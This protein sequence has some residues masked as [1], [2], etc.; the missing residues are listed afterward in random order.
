M[1]KMSKLKTKKTKNMK[2]KIVTVARAIELEAV[3]IGEA[4]LDG[5]DCWTLLDT[6]GDISLYEKKKP[7]QYPFLDLAIKVEYKKYE[8]IDWWVATAIIL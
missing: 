6:D 1:F 8:G 2:T 3:R 4:M 7:S 5:M